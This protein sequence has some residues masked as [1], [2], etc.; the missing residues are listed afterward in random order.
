MDRRLRVREEGDCVCGHARRAHV[1]YGLSSSHGDSVE[2]V[3]WLDDDGAWQW[4]SFCDE[5]ECP[6][7]DV[8]ELPGA[9]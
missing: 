7:V 9:C 1:L 6:A 5:C 8:L 4:A 3:G 2:L